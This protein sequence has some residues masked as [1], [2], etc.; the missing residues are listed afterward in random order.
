MAP[1]DPQPQ[2]QLPP[3]IVAGAAPAKRVRLIDPQGDEEHADDNPW[4]HMR[5]QDTDTEQQVRWHL[6]NLHAGVVPCMCMRVE[7]ACWLACGWL[8]CSGHMHEDGSSNSGL[9]PAPA[10]AD[11]MHAAVA[12][13]LA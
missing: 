5:L 13:M 3:Y 9:G 1:L 12:N 2:Q 4:L 8:A 10:A 7:S 11:D 6:S